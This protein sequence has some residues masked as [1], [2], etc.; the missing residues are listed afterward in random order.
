LVW[1]DGINSLYGFGLPKPRPGQEST[2]SG[3]LLIAP[4]VAFEWGPI[5]QP[6]RRW[7]A[8]RDDS[9]DGDLWSFSARTGL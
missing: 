8:H 4:T 2:R 6:G 7:W 1:I 9:A 3:D 5:S